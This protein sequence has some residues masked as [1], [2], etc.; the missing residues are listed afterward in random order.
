MKK[1]L[2]MVLMAGIAL[3][4]NAQWNNW[5]TTQAISGGVGILG[6]IIAS[7][8]RKKAMEI[9]EREK[10][11]YQPTFERV[12]NEAKSLESEEKWADALDKYEEAAQLNCDYGYTDQKSVTLKINSLY[13]K[14]GRTEEGPSVLNNKTTILP[15][16]T[17][18]RFTA[19]NP[20]S[21]GKKDNTQTKIVRVSCSDTETRIELECEADM[22]NDELYIKSDTY[23]RSKGGDKLRLRSVENVTVAPVVTKIPWPYQKLR[24]ALIFPALPITAEEFELVEP[25]SSWKFR[26]IRCR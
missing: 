11:Q 18:Y 16:Y 1:I 6:S 20:I 13:E 21:K 17:R 25:S 10:A 22:P 19:L 4:T 23:I 5:H 7:S 24:F 12:Y 3:S 8:E 26:N 2:M 15:D 14:A 9:F